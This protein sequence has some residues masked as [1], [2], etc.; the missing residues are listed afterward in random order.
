MVNAIDGFYVDVLICARTRVNLSK[1]LLKGICEILINNRKYDKSKFR[2][3]ISHEFNFKR[4]SASFSC[5]RS[6]CEI[7]RFIKSKDFKSKY[8][9]NCVY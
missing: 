7:Y 4:R 2:E 1:F 6:F 3:E 9:E 5:G 8:G